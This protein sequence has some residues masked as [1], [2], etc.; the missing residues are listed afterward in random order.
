[1]PKPTDIRLVSTELDS[2]RIDYRSPIKF[3]GRVVT[4]VVIANVRLEVETQDGRRGSGFG[5]MPIGNVWAW[6]SGAVTPAQ[7]L[8]AMQRFF[9]ALAKAVG[10][11]RGTGHP[12]DITRELAQQHE[13]LA[14]GIVK[15]LGLAEP[16]PL[17]AQMV[18]ASPFEAAI[19]DAYGRALGANSY[20]LLGPEFVQPRSGPLPDAGIR[21]RVSRP[22]HAP[23]AQGQDA[24]VSP[25]R[26]ARSAHRRAM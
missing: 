20:D 21:G 1:M 7:S 23:P 4:D 2:E 18:A 17:L 5:S 11:Y 19:H 22:V 12:L 6:P 15:S 14:A 25:R 9:E 3:G 24:P 8:D 10:D 26:G 13:P 16:M